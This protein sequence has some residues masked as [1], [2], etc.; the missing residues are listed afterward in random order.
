MGEHYSAYH[1]LPSS[2]LITSP[3]GYLIICK[4]S[5]LFVSNGPKTIQPQLPAPLISRHHNHTNP[6]C[7]VMIACPQFTHCPFLVAIPNLCNFLHAHTTIPSL[8]LNT[9]LL[10]YFTEKTTT[11]IIGHVSYLQTES[12]SPS[13]L[14]PA[15]VAALLF[16]PQAE[17]SSRLWVPCS[18]DPHFTE[19]GPQPRSIS[20]NTELVRNTVS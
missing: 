19:H 1:A 9:T 17:P 6:H 15:W 8:F 14:H 11:K 3:L 5:D 20:I 10:F 16:P 4:I 7:S 2:V 13:S 12:A 18:L